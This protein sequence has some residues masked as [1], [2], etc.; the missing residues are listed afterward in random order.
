[1][2][3]SLTI[4][5]RKRYH[6]RLKYVLQKIKQNSNATLCFFQIK[7]T[8]IFECSQMKPERGLRVLEERAD[9]R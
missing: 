3:I 6:D 2:I 8:G 4:V 9:V 7:K 5:N 1:M